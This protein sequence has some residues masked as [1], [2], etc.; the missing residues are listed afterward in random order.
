MRY[1]LILILVLLMTCGEEPIS[2]TP[3]KDEKDP[4]K[5][6]LMVENPVCGCDGKT[7]MNACF[8]SKNGVSTYKKDKCK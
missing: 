5:S 6:C 4:T 3:C 8:A 7:Y 2:N 1:F